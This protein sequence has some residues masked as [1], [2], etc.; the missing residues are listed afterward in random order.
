MVE[1]Q[2]G[3]GVQAGDAGHLVLAQLE[4]EDIEVLRHP[5]GAH[6]ASVAKR[7]QARV[8]L[9]RTEIHSPVNG[10]VTNL[11]AQLGDYA[12]VGKNVIALVDANSFWVDAYFEE[13]QLAS[14][15]EGDPANLKIT[16]PEDLGLVAAILA[17]ERETLRQSA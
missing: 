2:R 9:E 17:V 16:F 7:D 15:R 8:N 13:T 14:I 5:V 1:E 3:A 12:T 10:W 6:P 4:V 11:L